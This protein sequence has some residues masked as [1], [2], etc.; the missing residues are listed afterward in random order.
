MTGPPLLWDFAGVDGLSVARALFGEAVARLS[1]WQSREADRDGI[2]CSLL[3][4]CE[5]NFRLGLHGR[6]TGALA[7]ALEQ[8]ARGRRVW[9]KSGHRAALHVRD[10]VEAIIPVATVKPPHR[11]AGLP[12]NRAVPARLEDRAVLLWRHTVGGVRLVEV[13]MAAPDLDGVRATLCRADLL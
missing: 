4:L 7:S 11:L 5:G 13:H 9:V 2:P 6:D 12:M 8:V 10:A 1:V 3:R